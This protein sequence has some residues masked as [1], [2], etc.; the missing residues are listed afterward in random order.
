MILQFYSMYAISFI[1]SIDSKHDVYTG[2]DYM[3]K[4]FAFL[5]EHAMK[6]AKL[7]TKG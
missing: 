7:L 4:F 2:K 6:K 1:R 3:K 5:R